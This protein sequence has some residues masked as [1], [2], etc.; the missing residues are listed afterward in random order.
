MKVLLTDLIFLICNFNTCTVAVLVH[1]QKINSLVLLEKDN[2]V[3]WN[4][5]QKLSQTVDTKKTN[6]DEFAALIKKIIQGLNID[7]KKPSFHKRKGLNKIL[8]S[9]EMSY[10][11][12]NSLKS[13]PTQI[14]LSELLNEGQGFYKHTQKDLNDYSKV[15]LVL[16]PESNLSTSEI[17]DIDNL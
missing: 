10:I 8:P 12:R 16:N 14:A 5:E 15:Y 3:L 1:N 7:R 4:D 13:P 2:N 9:K 17:Q 11:N 6:V